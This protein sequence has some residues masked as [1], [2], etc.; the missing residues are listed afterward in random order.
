MT[1]W[2]EEAGLVERKWQ[3]WKENVSFN[4]KQGSNEMNN[5]VEEL[6]GRIM[7]M[8]KMMTVMKKP[9]EDRLVDVLIVNTNT[10]SK[11]IQRQ[12]QIQRNHRRSGRLLF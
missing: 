5:E 7:K 1:Y 3:I 12:I 10:N 9:P 4:T 6:V 11:Q 8:M 2:I